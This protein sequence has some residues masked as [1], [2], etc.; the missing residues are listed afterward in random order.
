MPNKDKKIK[1]LQRHIYSMECAYDDLITNY[2]DIYE[3]LRKELR[4]LQCTS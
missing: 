4:E 2:S 1:E 3:A